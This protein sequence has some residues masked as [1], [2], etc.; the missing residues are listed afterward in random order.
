M[1]SI[2]L[3]YHWLLK[4]E[5]WWALSFHCLKTSGWQRPQASES[6][7]NLAS[8]WPPGSVRTEEGKNGPFGPMPSPS[9]LSGAIRGLT[10]WSAASGRARRHCCQPGTATSATASAA[11]AGRSSGWERRA[12]RTKSATEPSTLTATWA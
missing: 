3:R 8:M 6:R 2:D 5:K 7:K 4:D 11:M 1:Y 9:M 10:T 12:S